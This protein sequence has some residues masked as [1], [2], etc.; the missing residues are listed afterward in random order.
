[1]F[2]ANI[3]RSR[4]LIEIFRVMNI[5]TTDAL[6]FSDV[7]RASLVM[8]ISAL[9]H[10]IHE[11]VRTGMLDS[12]RAKRARTPAFLRFQVSIESVLHG[13]SGGTQSEEW[14]ESQIR[15]QHGHLSFQMPDRIAEAIRLISSVALWDEVSR[16]LGMTQREVKDR[17][18]LIVQ[19]RNK[20]AHE[21]DTIPDYARQIIHSDLR[22]PI[23]ERMV[24]DAI[25]FIEK[26]A[27]SI[28]SL[29]SQQ[30]SKSA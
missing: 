12:Y 19:R 29:V 11:I 3:R 14:L 9:D 5:Q 1:M 4:D 27:G 24:D 6:D 23:D 22:S 21:A 20:I 2:Q 17:M 13:S 10:F 7:L 16:E 25:S 28:Y 26:V 8:S 18:A 30:D 15:D